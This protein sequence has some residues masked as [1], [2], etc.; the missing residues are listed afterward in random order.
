[1][2]S[3]QFNSYWDSHYPECEPIPYWLREIYSERWFRIHAL[4]ESKR[5]PDNELEYETI[6]VRHNALLGELARPDEELIFVSATYSETPE[7][8]LGSVALSAEDRG[9]WWRTV[10]V[11]ELENDFE[12]PNYWHFFAN[13]K[14]WQPRT[15]D[16]L[17]RPIADN[18]IANCLLVSHESHWIYHPY[19]G[20][21][22][23]IV[24]CQSHRD[25]LQQKFS[26]WLSS[27]PDGV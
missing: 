16:P 17:L 23:I 13:P 14:P 25:Q 1:M 4:P 5:Y 27:H 18:S 3:L 15:L 11:H 7:Y 12:N 26:G 2:D 24:Q 20:G 8:V 21:A 9:G 6:L 19:D 22:D 10:P